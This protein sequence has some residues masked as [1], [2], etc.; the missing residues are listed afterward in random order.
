MIFVLLDTIIF[1]IT[2][3]F[4][5]LLLMRLHFM[6]I[7]EIFFSCLL[8]TILT[9]NFLLVF[10]IIIMYITDHILFKYAKFNLLMYISTFTFYYF[11]LSKDLVS[12]FINL[13]LIILFYFYKYNYVG[14]K[15]E[16]KKIH[17]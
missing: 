5:S 11:I 15:Y 7:I 14:E 9:N 6:D 1:S 3:L 16:R 2:G 8:L 13:F 12:Y 10:L 17:K 4:S